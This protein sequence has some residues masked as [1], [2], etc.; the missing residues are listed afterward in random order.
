MKKF[1]Y[2][3]I[4]LFVAAPVF[5]QDEKQ[6][7]GLLQGAKEIIEYME[8]TPELGVFISFKNL[9][10]KSL[11][12]F[13]GFAG[14]SGALYKFDSDGNNLGSW[15]IGGVF[16]GNR[17][18]YSTLQI[19]G[20]GLAKRFLSDD[21]KETLSP[22]AMGSVWSFIDEYGKLAVGVG[23]D[24]VEELFA[25]DFSAKDHAGLIGTVGISVK[26]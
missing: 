8:P 13:E 18:L 12:Q 26:F 21:V 16:E 10:E 25:S 6:P 2:L 4:A 9:Q 17:K 14:M 11:S 22:G 15:R 20:I 7:N 5:A 3:I 1:L 24:D 19:N 23:L